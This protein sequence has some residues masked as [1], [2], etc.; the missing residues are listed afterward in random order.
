VPGGIAEVACAK[1]QYEIA[2]R[3]FGAA[4]MLRENLGLYP[5]TDRAHYDRSVAS[6]RAALSKAPFAAAWA[7]GRALTLEQAIEYA[8]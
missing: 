6:T 2:A 5:P 1:G 7:E 3:L 4:E 8:L